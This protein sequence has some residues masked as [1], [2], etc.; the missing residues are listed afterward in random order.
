MENLKKAVFT[1]MVEKIS[2]SFQV[3]YPPKEALFTIIPAVFESLDED[4]SSNPSS[5]NDEHPQ[6]K[7]PDQENRQIEENPGEKKIREQ[8]KEMLTQAKEEAEEIRKQAFQDGLAQGIAEGREKGQREVEKQFKPLS[9]TLE[10]LVQQIEKVQTVILKEQ[11]KEIIE[12]CLEIA[13][14]IIKTEIQ[15]NPRVI[16]TTL[17][18]ALKSVGHHTITS[19]KL[20]PL[21]LELFQQLKSEISKSI[22]NLDKITLEADPS[23]QQGGCLIQTDLGYVDAGLQFQ[24][25]EIEKT[26]LAKV[27]D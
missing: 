2:S 14:K 21:D 22:L 26:L 20:H 24:F 18:E 27:H 3:L 1:P 15:Q 11:E 23:L 13:K 16:L 19:I 10:H 12:L 7:S 8:I 6:A 9:S 5:M 17:T 25:R 4:T